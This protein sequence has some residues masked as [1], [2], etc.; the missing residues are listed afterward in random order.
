MLLGEFL[1][2]FDDEMQ[3][4]VDYPIDEKANVERFAMKFD[5][6]NLSLVY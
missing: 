6:N 1:V 2:D 4:H 3:I 5:E